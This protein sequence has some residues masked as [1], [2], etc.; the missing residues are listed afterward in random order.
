MR[1][2]VISDIHG[3]CF[4]LDAVLADLERRPVDAMICLGDAIQ[5]GP[6]PAETVARLR[7]LGCPVVMGNADAYLLSGTA[8]DAEPIEPERQARLDAVRAWSLTQLSEADRAF[9]AD[10]APTVELDLG[11]GRRLLAFHG[12]PASFDELIL[13]LTPD[14]EL[15]RMLGAHADKLLCGGHTHV[16]Q[17]RHLGRSF[18]FNPGA[19]GFAWRHGQAPD[20]FRA[21][22]WAEYA[23]LAAEGDS[24]ALEFRRVPYDPAALL[25]IYRASGRPFL[26]EAERQYGST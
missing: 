21:D 13:P 12:S 8:D 9:V 20:Q 6:Q 23:V 7:S 25:A 17:I 26:D 16:Q 24:L 5:G 2:A 14:D 4:A 3:N 11:Q 10:F 15:R 22:P 18:F 19:V 1:L